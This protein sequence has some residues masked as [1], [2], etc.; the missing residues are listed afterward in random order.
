MG[1]SIYIDGVNL[2]GVYGSKEAAFGATT[3]AAMF[4]R[5]GT[6]VQ[7]NVPSAGEERHRVIL[8]SHEVVLERYELPTARL[9][10]GAQCNTRTMNPD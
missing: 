3:V 1:W 8:P 9:K 2:G 7:I 6:G 10:L 4:V 5:D